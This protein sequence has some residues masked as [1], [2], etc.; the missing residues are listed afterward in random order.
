MKYWVWLFILCLFLFPKKINAFG[1]Y[2][3]QSKG[4]DISFPQCPQNFP[5]DTYDFGIIGVNGGKS[6]T[7]NPCLFDE[8]VWARKA[9]R[10]AS[11]YMNTNYPS[12]ST[13]KLG[14]F[15]PLGNCS[16]NDM[17]C[18]AYNYGYNAAKDAYEYALSQLTSSSIWWLDVETAN[19]WSDDTQFNVRVVQGAIDYFSSAQIQVGIYSTKRAWRSIM[20]TEYVPKQRITDSI[21]NWVGT[22]LD[23]IDP[24]RCF[25]PFIPQS[26]VWIIQYAHQGF[27]GNYT[28]F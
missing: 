13:E 17:R 12:G 23:T 9:H 8:S 27:D 26:S 16:E 3:S 22:G 20:G 21:P 25:Q 5:S 28:C 18:Q 14:L 2:Q 6:F 7:G 24:L 10:Q 1:I 4:Y 15:G 11:L 19:T